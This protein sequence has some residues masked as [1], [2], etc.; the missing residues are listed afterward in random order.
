MP[1]EQT[2]TDDAHNPEAS[3]PPTRV[4]TADTAPRA[5]TSAVPPRRPQTPSSGRRLTTERWARLLWAPVLLVLAGLGMSFVVTANHSHALSPID[6]WVYVDYL[7]K[8]PHQGILQQG[9]IIGHEALDAMACDGVKPYG[10]MGPS[11]R[12]DYSD[13]SK[14]PFAARTS[15]DPYTPVYFAITRVIGDAIHTVTGAHELTSWRLTGSIWL[16][17]TMILMYWLMRLWRVPKTVALVL[18]LAFI[19]SPYAW[20]TFTYVSTDAP[21]MALGT[22]LLIAATLYIRGRSSGWWVVGLSAF[23]LSIKV[24]NIL[25]VCLVAL[26]LGIVWLDEFIAKRRRGIE[27]PARRGWFNPLTLALTSIVAAGIV[28]VAWLVFRHL[29]SVGES[30]NQAISVPLTAKELLLQTTTFLPG[31]IT[32]NVNISGSTEFAYAIPTFAVIPLSWLCIAGVV[33]AFWA[34]KKTN[35]ARHMIIAV[36]ISAVFFAPMLAIVITLATGAYFPLPPRYGSPMLAAFLMLAGMQIRNRW[37]T[38]IIGVYA[39]AL[40][41]VVL[42]A[43]P[44]LAP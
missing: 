38:A 20:W 7:Y 8:L 27:P 44:V 9:E 37:A 14:F 28:E 29:V 12:G 5:S 40:Y 11:C 18:G 2:P 19:G 42:A 23:A 3:A 16:A 32:S 33:G 43:A 26:Y 4:L 24:T 31:T 35:P 6:E 15:A 10:P 41:V 22:A 30:A 17:L 39:V 13:L 1:T 34:L 25:A 21:T 36:T